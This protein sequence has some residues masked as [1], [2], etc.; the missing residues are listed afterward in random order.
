MQKVVQLIDVLAGKVTKERDE[1]AKVFEEYAKFCDDE[2]VAKEYAITDSKDAI[3]EHTATIDYSEAILETEDS[4]V[5]DLSTKISDTESE[6]S[7][8]HALRNR[9]HESW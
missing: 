6:L 3:E 5:A 4:E 8:A 1:A 9:E 2:V 7:T